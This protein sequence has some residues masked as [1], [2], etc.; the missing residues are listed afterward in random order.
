MII[1]FFSF[2]G[3]VGKTILSQYMCQ[4]LNYKNIEKLEYI[5]AIGIDQ[6]NINF[7]Q[8]VN[9]KQIAVAEFN[10]GDIS[11]DSNVCTVIDYATALNKYTHSVLNRS[12]ILIMP[13]NCGSIDESILSSSF[14]AL[15]DR[16]SIDIGRKLFVLPN[17]YN[18]NYKPLQSNLIPKEN[19]LPPILNS[20]IFK[21]PDIQ[22]FGK[23]E[24][25]LLQPS[26]LPVFRRFF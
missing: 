14:Y 3:G 8:G 5:R 26:Y 7:S 22:I 16:F 12:D 23:R 11:A 1:T 13:Y 20:N 9:F 2:K 24:L 15:Q 18:R 25:Y 19:I 4:Y 17:C 21:Y 6:L 10:G